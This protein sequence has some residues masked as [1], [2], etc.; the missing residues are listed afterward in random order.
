MG[1]DGRLP[2]GETSRVIRPSGAD[3][4]KPRIARESSS[5]PPS[6]DQQSRALAASLLPRSRWRS[7][8]RGGPRR[9]SAAAPSSRATTPGTSASTGCRSTRSSDAIVRSIGLERHHARRLRLRALGRRAD[10]HPVRDRRRRP[11]QGAGGAST[12]PTSPTAGPIRSRRAPRSRAGRGAD[13]DRHVIVVDRT[14]CRLYELF[15]AYPQAGGARWTRRLGRDLE[16]ALEPAAP[17]RLDVGRRR[18]PADPAR[19]GPLRRGQARRDRPRAALHR[20]PARAARSSTRR[21]TSPR[22]SNDPNLPAMGQRLRLQARLR[23]LAL[24]APGAHR[25]EGAQALRDDPG[26]QRLALVRQRRA[27]P[28]LEQRPAPHAQPGAGQRVRGR[29]HGAGCRTRARCR[30]LRRRL[31]P[32]PGGRAPGAAAARRASA[33]SRSGRRSRAASGRA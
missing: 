12:T 16:P 21:A 25:P 7:R 31:R 11:A 3:V 19:A 2:E 6:A 27:R 15:A 10:R 28:A 26:R 5:P 29:R 18:R 20:R 24:P 4:E 32:S 8:R 1:R 30:S 14:R 23:H 13:G 9:A 22:T 17:A 33:S